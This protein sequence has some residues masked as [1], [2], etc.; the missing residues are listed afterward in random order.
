MAHA[1][2]KFLQTPTLKPPF[3]TPNPHTEP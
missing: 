1:D 3:Q 2:V